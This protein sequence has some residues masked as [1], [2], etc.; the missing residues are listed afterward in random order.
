[1]SLI[2]L[3]GA[4]LKKLACVSS[5]P[6]AGCDKTYHKL[7]VACQINLQSFESCGTCP[8]NR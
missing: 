6:R 7:S 1:M 8:R 4:E 2:L 5:G 3:R